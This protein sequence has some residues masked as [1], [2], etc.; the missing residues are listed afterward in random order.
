[1]GLSFFNISKMFFL[2]LFSLFL[3]QYIFSQ[4]NKYLYIFL[5]L[6]DVI[7]WVGIVEKNIVLFF[8][9]LFRW[10][11]VLFLL[12]KKK[13]NFF[14][15]LSWVNGSNAFYISVFSIG[16]IHSSFWLDCLWSGR[17]TGG[18]WS[19]GWRRT[20]W[21]RGTKRNQGYQRNGKILHFLFMKFIS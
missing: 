13:L 18:A 12:E 11:V 15:C 17:S 7:D 5:S 2:L 21:W 3:D 1:M 16:L 10:D 19:T 8:L 4:K 20:T 14:L 6:S 9:S